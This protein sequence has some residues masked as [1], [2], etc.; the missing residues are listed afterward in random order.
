MYC[1]QH[2]GLQPLAGGWGS[3][4]AGGSGRRP[5]DMLVIYVFSDSD[6]EYRRNLEFFVTF[7]MAEGDGC[8]YIIVVQQV[9]WPPQRTHQ[10]VPVPQYNAQPTASCSLSHML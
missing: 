10:S 1:R 9:G 6:S 4:A 5:V 7:G 3:I 8:D 2:S